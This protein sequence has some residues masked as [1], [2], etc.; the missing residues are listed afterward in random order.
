[1]IQDIQAHLVT[2]ADRS[3]RI[4][5]SL[6]QLARSANELPAIAREQAQTLEH[7]ARVWKPPDPHTAWRTP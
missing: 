6:D 1:V 7:I 4:C 5:A 3:D 2:Q